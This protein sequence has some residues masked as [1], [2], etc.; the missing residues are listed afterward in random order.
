MSEVENLMDK[1]NR[2]RAE[3]AA[4]LKIRQDAAPHPPSVRSLCLDQTLYAPIQLNPS[5]DELY[6]NSLKYGPHQID[7]HCIHCRQMSTFRTLT[8]R[9]A[10][11]VV[12]A[13]RIANFN[14]PARERLKRLRLES[15]QFA[16]HIGCSRR[17]DHLYSYFF[18][19]DENQAILQK[20]GQIPSVE[21][22][23]GVD[24]ERYR[25]ILGGDFSELRRATGLFAHGIGIGSF[26]YLRRI[27]ENLVE[28]A[29]QAADPHD[30]RKS[31]FLA[32]KMADR[33]K[34][35]STQLPPA[36]VKYKD[37]YGI[38][39]KGLHELTETECRKYFPVVRAAIIAMLE[40]RYEAKE[41]AKAAADLD[42]AISAIA[43]ET[44]GEQSE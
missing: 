11:D 18:H 12:G 23:A 16:L 1:L 26:V 5:R 7:A 27:F 14:A 38:L 2:E 44:K 36:V 29:R 3:R 15:G 31:E 33:V 20:I 35:L 42:K 8:D 39:S 43:A 24:I 30:E 41:K 25:K 6:I 21:D 17:P 40:Q 34:G 19:Y 9:Q 22:V 37:A 28:S 32:M 10:E 13:E 4:E